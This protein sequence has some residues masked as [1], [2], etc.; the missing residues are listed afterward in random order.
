MASHSVLSRSS[1]LP[2]SQFLYSLQRKKT[3]MRPREERACVRSS[4][5][6]WNSKPRTR[7][8]LAWILVLWKT[9]KNSPFN[10]QISFSLLSLLSPFSSSILINVSTEALQVCLQHYQSVD[11]QST[12]AAAQEGSHF[13]FGFVSFLAYLWTSDLLRQIGL[14]DNFLF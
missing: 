11:S 14:W 5:T 9:Y 4:A 3:T 6:G 2:T 7:R 10:T 1:F 13:Y 8:C 12:S